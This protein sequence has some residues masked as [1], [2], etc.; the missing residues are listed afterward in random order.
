MADKFHF[1]PFPKHAVLLLPIA[2]KGAENRIAE[3]LVISDLLAG[4]SF[5]L[6]PI[7]ETQHF[8]SG[9]RKILARN[10]IAVS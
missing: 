7:F 10:K 9:I 4:L 1:L 3:D 5:S 2:P 6:K 8:V